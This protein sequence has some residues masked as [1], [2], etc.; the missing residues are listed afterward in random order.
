RGLSPGVRSALASAEHLAMALDT[1]ESAPPRAVV[2][3]ILFV[4]DN[5]SVVE[6]LTAVLEGAGY[7]VV[8]ARDG[9]Q[10]HSA[11][12]MRHPDLVLC[13]LKLAGNETGFEICERFKQS[14]RKI[15]VVMLTAIDLPR[16][17]KLA[18]RVGADG[19][20]TKPIPA[21]DLLVQ[22]R[23]IADAVYQ[24]SLAE[25]SPP[26]TPQA[27][28]FACRCGKRFKVSEQHRGKTLTCPSCGEP[29][30]VPRHA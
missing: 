27:I 16:A 30:V 6:S 15:P 3:R 21:A 7:D 13:D 18:E 14:N 9:G 11:F 23:S 12:T 20:L 5:D 10:A 28:R 26:A 1:F 22:I 25:D 17:R 19:Y 8:V 29:V 2:H 24:K 4:D